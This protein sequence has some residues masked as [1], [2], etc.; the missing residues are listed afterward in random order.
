MSSLA[1]VALCSAQLTFLLG[2]T[3]Y[4]YA[5]VFISNQAGKGKQ[6]DAMFRKIPILGAALNIPLHAFAALGYDQFRKPGTGMW[7]LFVEQFNEGVEVDLKKSFYIG[8]A[9]GRPLRTGHS[10][11]HSDTDRSEF[12]SRLCDGCSAAER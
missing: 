4:S 11:D 5:I 1:L 8:D 3:Y 9:A 2:P 7:D 10:E 6:Q 12:P